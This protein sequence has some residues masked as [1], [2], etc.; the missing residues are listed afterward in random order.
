MSHCQNKLSTLQQLQN[1]CVSEHNYHYVMFV[2]LSLS[3]SLCMSVVGDVLHRVVG[4]HVP[5]HDRVCVL[6]HPHGTY[7]I[8]HTVRVRPLCLLLC[9][10]WQ[11]SRQTSPLRDDR[12]RGP[13]NQRQELPHP[14][15]CSKLSRQHRVVLVYSAAVEDALRRLSLGAPVLL[16]QCHSAAPPVVWPF[17]PTLSDQHRLT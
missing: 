15:Q 9:H 2:V 1:V 3:T 8:I 5:V 4:L 14:T 16:L 7:L 11:S 10:V 12:L 17:E 6:R 13:A